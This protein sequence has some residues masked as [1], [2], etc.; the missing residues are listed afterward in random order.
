MNVLSICFAVMVKLAWRGQISKLRMEETENFITT[1]NFYHYTLQHINHLSQ[2][3]FTNGTFFH[4]R[5]KSERF[6]SNHT[7]KPFRE[8]KITAISISRVQLSWRALSVCAC[9]LKGVPK[10]NRKTFITVRVVVWVGVKRAYIY[11]K[12]T[13]WNQTRQTTCM[14]QKKNPRIKMCLVFCLP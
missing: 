8:S 7:Q 4:Y 12:R 13:Q 3:D 9:L 1:H 11:K 14:Q 6:N 2:H 5:E 10:G